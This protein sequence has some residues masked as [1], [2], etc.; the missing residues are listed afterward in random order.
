MAQGIIFGGYFLNKKEFKKVFVEWYA[1]YFNEFLG[2]INKLLNN[3][4]KGFKSTYSKEEI[5]KK[6]DEIENKYFK[7][8]SV[9]LI[10]AV[11][12]GGK[13][14][15]EYT[16]TRNIPEEDALRKG[17]LSLGT[18][19]VK[20]AL[21][22]VEDEAAAIELNRLMNEHYQHLLTSLTSVPDDTDTA[23]LF[24]Y[25]RNRSAKDL[26]SLKNRIGFKEEHG[27]LRK[28]LNGA[29]PD[30]GI[31]NNTQLST[32][33]Y[34]SSISNGR[35]SG[36]MVGTEGKIH[37]AYMNHVAA[38]HRI[39][40]KWFSN[41]SSAEVNKIQNE[42]KKHKGVKAEEGPNFIPLLTG[43]LNS[44]SWQSGGD[45]VVY[46]K[47]RKVIYNIQLKTTI[48]QMQSYHISVSK[49][50]T[51]LNLLRTNGEQGADAVAELMF[52][53]FYNDAANIAPDFEN[54]VDEMAIGLAKQA[55]GL[56]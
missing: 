28:I 50:A 25:Y 34:G 14:T 46:N 1:K 35:A 13:E 48:Y 17:S 19:K 27:L 21:M 44:I 3:S 16:W 12:L 51:A 39:I 56:T 20:E 55:L 30:E 23:K 52:N 38:R 18:E 45:I 2:E 33:L 29:L 54:R 15:S 11:K 41:I 22:D 40:L 42:F 7:N 5:F 24:E 4:G 31:F 53:N 47:N 9:T 49:L 6:W 10:A 43:G 8:P 36:G 32:I 37:D 26:K